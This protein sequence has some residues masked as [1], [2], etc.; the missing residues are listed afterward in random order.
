MCEKGEVM[1]EGGIEEGCLSEPN[2]ELASELTY[3]V[4]HLLDV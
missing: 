4:V 2:S 1:A 3:H